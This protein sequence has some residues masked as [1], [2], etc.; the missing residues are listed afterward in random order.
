VAGADRRAI[1][2]AAS[3]QAFLPLLAY[4]LAILVPA[5]IGRRRG[6]RVP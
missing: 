5:M 3:L 4:G 6:E 1:G 2:V